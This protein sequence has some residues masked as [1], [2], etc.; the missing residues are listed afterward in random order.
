MQNS[1]WS[2]YTPSVYKYA[3]HLVRSYV[4]KNSGNHADVEDIL[5]EG[6]FIFFRNV[7]N[8]E[9][10]LTN[11]PEFY[12]YKTC[13]KLWL[14]ELDRRK[15]SGSIR[16]NDLNIEIK[17]SNSIEELILKEKLIK[18]I[19]K[20]KNKLSTKCQKVF[21][22]RKQGLSCED[23]AIQMH[24]NGGQIAKD[25]YYRCKK[26]LIQLIQEDEEYLLLI[27]EEW[28]LIKKEF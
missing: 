9:F 22:Y 26:R 5:Q 8:P 15:K 17:E 10:T 12:I 2:F 18:I 14:K 1:S 3:F 28:P 23:I 24:F 21:N 19:D 6:L 11:K 25:K 16:L 7:K 27:K 4:L 20:N 13:Q